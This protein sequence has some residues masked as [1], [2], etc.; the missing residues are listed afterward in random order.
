MN[1]RRF[2]NSYS[3]TQVHSILFYSVRLT[4]IYTAFCAQ[5]QKKRKIQNWIESSIVYVILFEF[6]VE[7]TSCGMQNRFQ[8]YPQSIYDTFS[9]SPTLLFPVFCLP[10]GNFNI[11]RDLT[12]PQYHA[13]N[14]RTRNQSDKLFALSWCIY[15][16]AVE[17]LH[18]LCLYVSVSGCMYSIVS[19]VLFTLYC[20]CW[21]M[22]VSYCAYSSRSQVRNFQSVTI[23]YPK[24]Y[25]TIS[26]LFSIRAAKSI[27][28]LFNNI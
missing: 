24:W 13:H 5:T 12:P 22:S 7:T 21:T 18:R 1:N 28:F 6:T 15:L 10:V 25:V 26:T 11:S 8:T 19:R 4:I 14:K 3:D 16:L 17:F 2:E 9:R 23:F 27:V 20:V